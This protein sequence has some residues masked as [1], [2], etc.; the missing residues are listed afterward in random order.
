VP[1]SSKKSPRKAPTQDRARD[2][3][4]VLL[5]ATDQL[6]RTGGTTAVSIA[7]IARRAG[8]A[9]GSVYQYFPTKSAVLAA[10]EEREWMRIGQELAAEVHALVEQRTSAEHDATTTEERVAFLKHAVRRLVALTARRVAELAR[11]YG[12]WSGFPE[13]LSNR[14]ER[15]RVFA[16]AENAVAIAFEAAVARGA[17]QVESARR[18][19]R[20]CVHLIVVLASLAGASSEEERAGIF[21]DIDDLVMAH[22]FKPTLQ[23]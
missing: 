12:D 15:K 11:I 23:M 6:I 9:Q 1:S 19:A 4:R 21:A 5:E 8:S 14:D 2:T 22:L 10:W 18:A 13:F 3:V 7:E 16:T 20:V 17:L